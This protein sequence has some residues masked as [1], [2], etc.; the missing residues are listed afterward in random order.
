[1]TIGKDPQ[2]TMQDITHRVTR[3]ISQIIAHPLHITQEVFRFIW[4][5][6]NLYFRNTAHPNQE[7]S[8]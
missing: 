5:K 4:E 8:D 3:Q 7:P 1:M 2:E 6:S